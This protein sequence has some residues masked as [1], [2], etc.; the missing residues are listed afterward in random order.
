MEKPKDGAKN[1][2]KSPKSKKDKNRSPGRPAKAKVT[3]RAGVMTTDS[4]KII[5]KDNDDK[6]MKKGILF[7]KIVEILVENVFN[8]TIFP[9]N[10]LILSLNYIY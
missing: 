10:Q 4:R 6:K 9:L 5:L 1:L 8:S 2:K 3:T 7:S